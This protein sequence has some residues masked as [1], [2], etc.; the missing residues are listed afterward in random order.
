MAPPVLQAQK[1]YEADR[2]AQEA[3]QRATL[4]SW[5]WNQEAGYYYNA[6]HRWYYDKSTGDGAGVG[7][8]ARRKVG[9]GIT[10]A[11]RHEPWSLPTPLC[12]A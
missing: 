5:E 9:D 11:Q 3:H 4:G 1:R 8:Q 2:K 6:L 12:L 10:L 7:G